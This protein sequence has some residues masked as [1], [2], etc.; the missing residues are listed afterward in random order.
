M[1]LMFAYFL[2]DDAGSAQDIRAYHQ[3]AAEM[4]HEVRL[5]GPSST[6][7]SLPHTNDLSWPDAVV[8]ICEWTTQTRHSD[9]LDFLRL[10]EKVP[11]H[12]RV[13][14]DCDGNYNDALNIEGDYNQRDTAGSEKWVQTCDALAEKICQPTYHPKRSNV[15]TFFFHAYDASWEQP[16][17]FSNKQFGMIYV[18]HS[19]F[20]WGPMHR[21]LRAI[22]PVRHQVRRIGIIGHGWDAQPSWSASMNMED[23]Y[24]TDADY[25]RRMG[26]EIMQPISS[27]QVIDWMSCAMFNPVIYRPLFSYLNFVTCRTFETVAA[28]TLPL[29]ALDANYVREIYGECATELLLPADNPE[30]KIRDLM[31]RPE[32]YA[33]V[34]QEMRRHLAEKHSYAARIRELIRIIN[35]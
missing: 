23:A 15:R 26:V 2:I 21:V 9:S 3:V 24:Q 4:G 1:R 17:D 35:E 28:G 12:K 14:V 18:G 6:Q 33:K 19:K 10:I 16:L 13:L 32:H 34:V 5:Y 20:R 7:S 29:F 22:E 11:R 27:D 25:M 8:F 30:L 31:R